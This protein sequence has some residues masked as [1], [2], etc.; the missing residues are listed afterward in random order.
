M[1]ISWVYEVLY[2]V[3]FDWEYIYIYIYIYIILKEEGEAR[4]VPSTMP[5]M[6]CHYMYLVCILVAKGKKKVMIVTNHMHTLPRFL[7]IHAYR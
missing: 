4:G 7:H 3:R 2:V 1:V 6:P 5:C